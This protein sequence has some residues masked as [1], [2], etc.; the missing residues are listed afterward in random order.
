MRTRLHEDR[1]GASPIFRLFSQKGRFK[2][3]GFRFPRVLSVGLRANEHPKTVI[4]PLEKAMGARLFNN[5]RQTNRGHVEAFPVLHVRSIRKTIFNEGQL[6]EG[7]FQLPGASKAFKIILPP[8]RGDRVQLQQVIM[9]LVMNAVEAMSN[10]DEAMRELQIG[11]GKDREDTILLTVHDS[12]P[13]LNSE[14]LDRFFQPFYSTK[15]AGMGIGLSICRSIVEAH[16][17]R[18]WATGNAPHG[19]T[20]HITLPVLREAAS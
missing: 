7:F 18:I 9:N 11:T 14:S 1:G 19:A 13:M 5:P 6:T 3:V 12:G 8:I 10:L 4:I 20:L 15:P 2:P 17:G 16:G